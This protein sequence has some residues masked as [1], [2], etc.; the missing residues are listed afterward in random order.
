MP[1]ILTIAYSVEGPT[2][3]RFLQNIIQRTFEEV[4]LLCVGDVEVFEAMPISNP[5]KGNF[6]DNAIEIARQ[7]D[8]MGIN[9]LC[10][11]TDADSD[12]DENAFSH[13]INPAFDAILKSKLPIC[14]NLV[15]IVP[16]QMSEAWMLADRGA[17]KSELGTQK[18]DADLGIARKPE[19]VADPKFAIAEAI[20]LAQ[21]DKP[22]KSR[23]IT[24]SDLYQPIGQK[25]RLEVL[26]TLPSYLKFK[27]SVTDA[28]KK[29]NY[30]Q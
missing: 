26:D 12:S 19:T 17:L 2:D 8:E 6:M 13:K 28:L 3:V 25:I 5:K 1:N 11:H 23:C 14:K 15:A 18:R 16:I 22:K 24:I 10:I 20:R 7:A 4:A 9:V 27:T 30:I 29:L 21:T